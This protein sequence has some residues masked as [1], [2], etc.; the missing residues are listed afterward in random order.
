MIFGLNPV[1]IAEAAAICSLPLL[2]LFFARKR[3]KT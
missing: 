1:Y 3:G 2:F